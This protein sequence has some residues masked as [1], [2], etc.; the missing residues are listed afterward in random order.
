MTIINFC[1]YIRKKINSDILI[2]SNV[3]DEI[4]IVKINEII[5]SDS[6]KELKES[7]S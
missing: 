6:A 2:T 7:Y 1:K 5:F 4:C 3:H